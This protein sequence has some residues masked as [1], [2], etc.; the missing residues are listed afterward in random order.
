MSNHVH[1][2][3]KPEEGSN[4]S[5]SIGETHRRY[6]RRINFREQWR[7]FLWQGQFASFPMNVMEEVEIILMF[8]RGSRKIY[9]I[10]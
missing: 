9:I 6:T 3:V 10:Y 1:L 8:Q 7:G 4:L 5:R 2:I